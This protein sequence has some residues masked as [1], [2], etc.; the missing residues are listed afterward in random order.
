[1]ELQQTTNRNPSLDADSV[2]FLRLLNLYK[3]END[4]ATPGLIDNRSLSGSCR[5][6]P[7]GPT[8][9]LSPAFLDEFMAQW[10][11]PNRQVARQFL[12]DSS[13]QLFHALRKT[14]DT[15]TEQRL[16]VDRLD[17]F[18]DTLGTS[19]S[20]CMLPC[21]GW[22][23]ARRKAHDLPR[24]TAEQ[25]AGRRPAHRNA[26][27][28]HVASVQHFS[29]RTGIGWPKPV[30]IYPQV[31]LDTVNWAC[32]SSHRTSAQE[33]HRVVPPETY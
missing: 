24:F 17:H 27:D 5:R 8:L 15:T 10:E 7:T 11:G 9:T 25:G 20:S 22:P 1:M 4:G 3:V 14:H 33:I 26:Q 32:S 30:T 19:P 28:R 23:S 2:E 21:A 16:D 31:T 13:G 12:G 29:G 18:F 6:P